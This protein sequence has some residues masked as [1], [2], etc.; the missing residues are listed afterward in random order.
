MPTQST[1]KPLRLLLVNP[2]IVMKKEHVHLGLATIAT[3]V[4]NHSPHD[5]RILDFMATPTRAWRRRLRRMLD[6]Y[7][8]DVVGMYLSSPYF[9]AAREVAAEI[10][11]HSN[12]PLVGGG[13][14]A[15]LATDEVLA[16]PHF[17]WVIEGEGEIGLAALL[18][19]VAGNRTL[20]DVPGLW[21]R[22]DGE[23]RGNPK[24]PLLDLNQMLPV[25][26]SVFDPDILEATFYIWGILPVTASRGCPSKCSFCS[27]TEI[28]KRYPG[29]RYLRYRDP[30]QVVREI[31]ADYERYR[32]LGLRTVQFMDLNFL[33]NKKW[34]REFAAEYIQA[35]LHKKLPYSV[36]SRPDHVTAENLALL[37]DSGCVN[38][39]IGVE[40]ANPW[41]R[42]EIYHKNIT[43]ERLEEGLRL[44]KESGISVTGYFMAGGP[45]ERPEWLLDSLKLARRFGIDFPVFFLYKPLADSEVLKKAD[46]L[47]SSIRPEALEEASDLLHG[48]SMAH[49]YLKPWQVSAFVLMTHMVFGAQLVTW[50]IRRER[51]SWFTDLARFMGRTIRMGFTP[52][53]SFTYYVFYAGDHLVE[54]FRAPVEH[55]PS[56]VW[57]AMMALAGLILPPSG[58]PDPNVKPAPEPSGRC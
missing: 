42:N 11:R 33:I 20:D 48:V 46:E 51:L 40:A 49:R 55:K 47:G 23:L 45:G 1:G 41:Q 27:M 13:H 3:W 14:H 19:A 28:Q 10:K 34:V 29:Q 8:P 36:F 43:Q 31:A 32:H 44:M 5:V 18:D 50:Q 56:L 26:W 52:Y 57:N 17:D 4:R 53:G 2:N 25:D 30:K 16:D 24:A 39:R 35:G 6:E 7:R 9:P 15:T 54:P 21:R 37:R 22:E 38:L 58:A 12:A